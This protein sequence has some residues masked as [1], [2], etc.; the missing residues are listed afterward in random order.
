MRFR[1]SILM[2]LAAACGD[3]V[4]HAPVER[5]CAEDIPCPAGSMCND[6]GICVDDAGS[7]AG[8]VV[9]SDAGLGTDG[10]GEVVPGTDG[11]EVVPG[12][13]AGAVPPVDAGLPQDPGCGDGILQPGEG[14]DDG[15][16]NPADGCTDECRPARCGDG[17]RRQDLAVDA[18]G[19]EACDDG[20]RLDNDSCTQRCEEAV[21]GDGIVWLDHEQCDDGNTAFSDGCGATCLIEPLPRECSWVGGRDRV[22]VYCSSEIPWSDAASECNLWHGDLVTVTAEADNAILSTAVNRGRD[23]TWIGLNDLQHEEELVWADRASDYRNW[24]RG[25]PDN[26]DNRDCAVIRE[27]E[28]TW[29]LRDCDD[30]RPFLCEKPAQ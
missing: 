19:G 11:G 16:Q 7:D 13:D 26:R 28:G 17:V 3:Q 18:P 5:V 2:V 21:C 4:V 8:V 29:K 27:P 6:V 24:Q 12:T 20:N 22:T 1:I 15:N 9:G 23:D 25:N 14:C 10:G 30:D